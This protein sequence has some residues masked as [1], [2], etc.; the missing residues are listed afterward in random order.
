MG[1]NLPRIRSRP[2]AYKHSSTS[3]NRIIRGNVARSNNSMDSCAGPSRKS[4]RLPISPLTT[5]RAKLKNSTTCRAKFSDSEP[6][7]KSFKKSYNRLHHH[8][9]SVRSAPAKPPN[10]SLSHS[11]TPSLL[12]RHRS[13]QNYEQQRT[14]VHSSQESSKNTTIRT[15]QRVSQRNS[16]HDCTS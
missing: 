2:R 15:R 7:S 11:S 1:W 14:T 5:W 4:S 10:T 6:H 13:A 3:A 16:A 9:Q 8:N 12:R